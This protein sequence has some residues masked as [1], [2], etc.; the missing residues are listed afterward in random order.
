M[1]V[2]FIL[3][4]LYLGSSSKY[5]WNK[6]YGFGSGSLDLVL[7]DLNYNWWFFTCRSKYVLD[8]EKY[9]LKLA[10]HLEVAF[11]LYVGQ[12]SCY[13]RMIEKK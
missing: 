9:T 12:L 5:R 2:P 10:S 6:E 4:K 8:I 3:L 7:V 1:L 11:S 13:P